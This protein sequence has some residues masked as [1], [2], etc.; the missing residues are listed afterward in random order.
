MGLAGVLQRAFASSLLL[1]VA[2]G[3]ASCST[4]SAPGALDAPCEHPGD[5][6][7]GLS[8]TAGVCAMPPIRAASR[9]AGAGDASEPEVDAR[10]ARD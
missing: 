1:A 6:E 8:C 3:D 10:D 5:C 4:D 9:E 7:P 2:V